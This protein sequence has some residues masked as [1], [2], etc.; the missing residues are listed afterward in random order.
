MTSFI[1]DEDPDSKFL[2]KETVHLYFYEKD[3]RG[4]EQKGSIRPD[5]LA[6]EKKILGQSLLR[7]WENRVRRKM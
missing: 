5:G 6:D 1:V 4:E 7:H 2:A 3:N